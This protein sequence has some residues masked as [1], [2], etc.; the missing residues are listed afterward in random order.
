M[1]NTATV[2]KR[3]YHHSEAWLKK[4]AEK[5]AAKKPAQKLEKK[6][7]V[8]KTAKKIKPIVKKQMAKKP[9]IKKQM[10]KKPLAK[11]PA[12]KAVAKKLV[13]KPISAKAIKKPVKLT[14]QNA[15]NVFTHAKKHVSGMKKCT[16]EIGK[17]F[18]EAFKTGDEKYIAKVVKLF[19]RIGYV[20]D[21][22]SETVS[23]ENDAKVKLP[24]AKPT[25]KS[26]VEKVTAVP[27]EEKVTAVPDEE[28]KAPE[29]PTVIPIV[30]LPGIP[31]IAVASNELET[32]ENENEELD[33]S[34][35]AIEFDMPE[36]NA[37]ETDEEFQDRLIEEREIAR[38][39]AESEADTRNEIFAAQE[40]NGD[41]S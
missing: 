2:T 19:E 34:D 15:V 36:K 13:K 1:N 18:T 16:K 9:S 22:L 11:K 25:K 33:S 32:D 24:K 31:E 38:D 17:F 40:E 4:H 29:M 7:I 3:S 35:D 39:M 5:L 27:D 10:A 23:F 41:F 21:S 30:E 8:K 12:Q 26:I 6:E 20:Y 37:D 14:M 28:T